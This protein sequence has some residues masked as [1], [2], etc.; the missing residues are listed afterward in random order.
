MMLLRDQ[1]DI[2]GASVSS[3]LD[4]CLVADCM[5]S[6]SISTVFQVT[7]H[8]R[9]DSPCLGRFQLRRPWLAIGLLSRKSPQNCLK[10]GDRKPNFPSNGVV[11]YKRPPP[12]VDQISNGQLRPSY[13]PRL[14]SNN[15]PRSFRRLIQG[16]S[17][18]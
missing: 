18:Q 6:C 15:L 2:R 3:M 12:L 10:F 17:T 9:R 5:L 7:A 14:M 1:D 8:H 11:Q 16:K 4:L 13:L